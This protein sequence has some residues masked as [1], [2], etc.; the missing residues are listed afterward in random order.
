VWTF[1]ERRVLTL[2]LFILCFWMTCCS[3]EKGFSPS[4]VALI[5]GSSALFASF[6][7]VIII[8]GHANIIYV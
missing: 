4:Q 7:T 3:I 8:D 2:A 6:P 5:F 1:F